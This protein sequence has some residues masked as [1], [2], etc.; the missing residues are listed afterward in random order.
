MK[1]TATLL[2]LLALCAA[3]ISAYVYFNAENSADALNQD[4]QR[5]SQ[6][7]GL[8]KANNAKLKAEN[9]DFA[10]KV[11]QSNLALDE[12]RSL[13]TVL[14]ARSNQLKREANRYSEELDTRFKQEEQLQRKLADQNKELATLKTTTV[15]IEE[16]DRYQNTIADLEQ[17]I[18]KLKSTERTFPGSAASIADTSTSTQND[19]K[20]K[21]LTVGAQSSFIIIDV[22]EKES[23]EEGNV[24]DVQRGG[25]TIAQVTITQVKENLSIAH[26]LP[27]SLVS[28]P[29]SGDTVTTF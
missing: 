20:G 12:A 22:G 15:S 16:I 14:T 6:Q 25:A 26:I 27:Q 4:L 9:S 17:R 29:R 28:E 8:E 1:T 21:I 13:N 18:L 10:S 24:L 23:A 5:V 11:T 2:Q 3:G 7:L 19:L